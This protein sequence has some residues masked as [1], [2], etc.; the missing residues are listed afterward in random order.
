M[1]YKQAEE[2]LLKTPL[3]GKKVGLRNIECLMEKMTEVDRTREESLKEYIK[4]VAILHITG[5]NGK[6][7]VSNM[8]HQIYTNAGYKVGLFT[9]PHLHTPRER[10]QVGKTLIEEEA[11]CAIYEKIQNICD[12][13]EKENIYPTFFERICCMAF[14]YFYQRNCE[15]IILEVGIGGR[16]DT[17]NFIEHSDVSVITSVSYDHM[18]ILGDTLE[19]IAKEKAGIIKR[20]SKV[21]VNEK[22]KAILAIYKKIAR[23]KNTLLYNVGKT[24]VFDVNYTDIGIDFS[25]DSKYYYYESLNVKSQALYQLENVKT[26]LGVVEAFSYKVEEEMIRKTLRTFLFP[27]RFE[28]VKKNIIL[29]GAHNIGGAKML[30]ASIEKYMEQQLGRK[31]RVSLLVGFKKDKLYEEM[32]HIYEQSDVIGTIYIT[33]G[34]MEKSI[35]FATIKDTFEN[36][37][38]FLLLEEVEEFLQEQTENENIVVVTGSLYLVSHIREIIQK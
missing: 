4:R 33:E 1:K 2:N 27:A 6:G 17:T 28:K 23:E 9:S 29:D 5:T 37:V 13:L 30:V 34:F 21:V 35:P 19:A 22:D 18:E 10:V 25:V 8:L 31:K 20:E 11:F 14:T 12:T 7:S 26:V 32:I 16:L 38:N 15:I 3:F 24:K 36:R